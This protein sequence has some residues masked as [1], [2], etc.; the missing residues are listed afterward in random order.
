MK[1]WITRQDGLEKLE[2]VDTPE[3]SDL[4]DGDVLVKINCVSL[5]YRDTEVCSGTFGFHPSADRKDEP[6]VPCSD[7]CGTVI[8]VSRNSAYQK[9]DRVM[10]I[11]KQSHLTGQMKEQDFESLLGAPLPGCLTQYRVFPSAGL[12]KVPQYLTDEEASTLPVA[13]V[14]A[15][16]ALNTFQPLGS[17]LKGRGKVVLIQ[18]TGGVSVSALQ[19]AHALQLTTIVTSSSDE[20]LK[21]AQQLGATYAINYKK[22]PDWHEAVLEMT[23]GKG[24]D[25]VLECGGA[26]TLAKSFKCVAFGGQISCVG[27]VSGKDASSQMNTNV[28]ALSRNVTLKGIVCGPKDRFEEMLQLYQETEV[29]PVIDRTFEFLEAKTALR[30]LAEGGH[31]GKVVVKVA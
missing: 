11:F 13:A 20:K 9:G 30:Y 5:N 23:D 28:L 10:A 17:P 19:M 1:Q 7:I 21:R 4:D 25:V 12:V 16:M 31:M 15:W 18:G 22:N 2:L 8:K 24:A 27:Y 3:P 29:H 14:T 6:I 26:D